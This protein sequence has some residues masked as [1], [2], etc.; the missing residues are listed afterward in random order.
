VL[1]GQS[2]EE[3]ATSRL[4]ARR[5]LAYPGMLVFDG[6]RR[7]IGID[8][9]ELRVARL[10]FFWMF[11]LATLAPRVLP[12]RMLSGNFEIGPDGRVTVAPRHP[13]RAQLESVVR[14]ITHVFVTLY[15]EAADEFP[16]VF[17]RAFGPTPGL[18]S[19]M[20]KLNAR[21]KRTLGA[22]ATP[23]LIAGGR[24]AGGYRLTMLPSQITLVPHIPA[25]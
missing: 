6:P 18:P 12:F 8:N 3:L 19:I 10:Q 1:P 24:G 15:P 25:P 16:L 14:H 2:Y 9:V 5:R 13:E 20:A 23:Y 21:L 11:C 4:L 17:K 7:T 22:G